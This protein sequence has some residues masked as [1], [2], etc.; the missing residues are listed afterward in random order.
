MGVSMSTVSRQFH[1]T[2]N[3]MTVRLEWLIKWPDRGELWK[4]MLNSFHV[5]FGVKVV[6][7]VDYYEIIIKAPSHLV[8]KS[9]IYSSYKHA[10][11]AKFL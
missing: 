7:I 6:A 11:T 10:H 5:C 1:K 8:A 2:L 3:L 9:S 4:T